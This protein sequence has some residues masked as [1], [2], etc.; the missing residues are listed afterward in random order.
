ML[1]QTESSSLFFLSCFIYVVMAWLVPSLPLFIS[2]F[3]IHLVFFNL[4]FWSSELFFTST[5]P[6]S[7]SLFL[8]K[9]ETVQNSPK[10]SNRGKIF[11]EYPISDC[12]RLPVRFSSDKKERLVLAVSEELSNFARKKRKMMVMT[13]VKSEDGQEATITFR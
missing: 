8:R 13:L 4:L 7:L 3:Q 1:R 6:S 11:Q 9:K 2:A 10:A 12:G 5:Y